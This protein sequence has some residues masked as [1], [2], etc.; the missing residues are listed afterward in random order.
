MSLSS[1]ADLIFKGYR[2]K[3]LALLLLHPDRSYHVREIARLTNTA[4]GTLHKELSKLEAVQIL[5]K[6]AQGNQLT[7]QAN[8]ECIIFDEL[9]SILRKTSGVAGVLA[10]ALS[11][12]ETKIQVAQIFGSVASGKEH[13][14]SDL[15]LLVIGDVTFSMLVKALYPAQSILNREINPKLY[16]FKEWGKIKQAESSFFNELLQKPVIKVIGNIDDIR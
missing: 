7:Y 15:D 3:V 8:K 6:Q 13:E 9:A 2:Q 14:F 11:G 1:L 10:D 16:N 12:L 5:T 4:A